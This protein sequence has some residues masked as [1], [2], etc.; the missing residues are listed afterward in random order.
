MSQPQSTFPTY[1][2]TVDLTGDQGERSG[3]VNLT[4]Q[5]PG[6]R[7]YELTTFRSLPSA[8]TIVMSIAPK[9]IPLDRR[10]AL[11]TQLKEFNLQPEVTEEEAI[12]VLGEGTRINNGLS[13][14]MSG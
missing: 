8:M 7:T 12:W 13:R 3:Y 2:L 11:L 9:Y 4:V 6:N 10:N 1:T 14:I 5:T